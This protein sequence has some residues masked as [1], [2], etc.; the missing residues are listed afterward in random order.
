MLVFVTSGYRTFPCS[1]GQV[2]SSRDES[3][4]TAVWK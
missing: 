4:G 1:L 2:F 3:Y